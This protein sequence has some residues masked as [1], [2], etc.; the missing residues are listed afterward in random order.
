MIQTGAASE[1]LQ[2]EKSAN[3]DC[4]VSLR[5]DRLIDARRQRQLT[6]PLDGLLTVIG[7]PRS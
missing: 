2:A 6:A 7:L 1:L 3:N 5:C 4:F